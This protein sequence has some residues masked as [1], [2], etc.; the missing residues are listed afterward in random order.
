M[1]RSFR[2]PAVR[3]TTAGIV[4]FSLTLLAAGCAIF[5]GLPLRGISLNDRLDI[6]AV[7]LLAPV[8]ALVLAL[9]FEVTAIALRAP[10]LPQPRQQR[11]VRWSPG[12]REG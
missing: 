5:A 11:P 2:Q 8:L 7:L 1:S 9:V 10:D 4:S 6:G 12:L 3:V